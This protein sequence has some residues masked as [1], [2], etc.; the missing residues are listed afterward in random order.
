MKPILTILL[1]LFAGTNSL[2]AA[3]IVDGTKILINWGDVAVTDP[4]TS[5]NEAGDAN[6]TGLA[7]TDT[8]G[9][10][11]TGVTLDSNGS[12][13]GTVGGT[14]PTPAY[15]PFSPTVAYDYAAV[16]SLNSFASATPVTALTF[17]GLDTGFSYTF[18][19]Y[20][21]KAG[22][23]DN[24]AT[25]TISGANS[26]SAT[27][28]YTADGRGVE[29]IAGI[30]P[31]A[32]GQIT[33]SILNASAGNTQLRGGLGAMEITAVVPEPGTFSLMGIAMGSLLL[34]R[35]LRSTASS[36]R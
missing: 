15:A 10:I 14:A 32:G 1:I 27:Y 33:M 19:F 11:L 25:Y 36:S 20:A 31:T 3:P 16:F 28:N 18:V 2:T 34:M 17:D 8:A 29:T 22:G 7:L 12:N 23:A 21:D 35:S 30:T 24:T 13:S 5:W 6:V 26:G 4:G 9:N